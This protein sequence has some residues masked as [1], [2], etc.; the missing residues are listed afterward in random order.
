MYGLGLTRQDAWMN[1]ILVYYGTH[2][3]GGLEYEKKKL[4]KLGMIAR[5][6][7]IHL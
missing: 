4:Q 7:E 5:K 6:V 2:G 1:A 3:H